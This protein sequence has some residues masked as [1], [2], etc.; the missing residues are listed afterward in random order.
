MSNSTATVQT[1]S[2]CNGTGTVLVPITNTQTGQTQVLTQTCT[3]CL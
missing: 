1:C 2:T 3:D